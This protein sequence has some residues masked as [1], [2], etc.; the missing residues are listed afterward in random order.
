MTFLHF[1]ANI[2]GWYLKGSIDGEQALLLKPQTFMNKSGIS[3][4]DAARFYKIPLD[5]IWVLYDELDLAVGKIR[6]KRGGGSGG[7]NGIKDIDR[8]F[9]C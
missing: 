1:L 9:R 8:H 5:H 4:A 2:T 3:V 7:H 6:I